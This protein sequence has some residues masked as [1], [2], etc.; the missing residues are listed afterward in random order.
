MWRRPCGCSRHGYY[1]LLR[2]IAL[3]KK[4]LSKLKKESKATRM[5]MAMLHRRQAPGRDP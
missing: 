3:S 1:A 2:L 4:A 5:I